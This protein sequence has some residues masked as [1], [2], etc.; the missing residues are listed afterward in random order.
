MG[1]ISA[2]FLS[3]NLVGIWEH[4]AFA[5]AALVSLIIIFMYK[6][7]KLQIS[8]STWLVIPL[9]IT[10]IAIILFFSKGHYDESKDMT[11][12]AISFFVGLVSTILAIF[13]LRKDEKTVQESNRLR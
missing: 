5:A 1:A 9:Y 3:M 6:K 10:G 12:L 4:F 13:S 8:L 2:G 7:R 11:T